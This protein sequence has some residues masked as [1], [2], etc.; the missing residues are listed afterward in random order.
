MHREAV[1]CLSAYICINQTLNRYW[2]MMQ[3]LSTVF[4]YGGHVN[5]ASSWSSLTAISS[6]DSPFLDCESSLLDLRGNGFQTSLQ[7]M[8][9]SAL[10][11]PSKLFVCLKFPTLTACLLPYHWGFMLWI[12]TISPASPGEWRKAFQ[13][14]EDGVVPLWC[15]DSPATEAASCKKLLQGDRDAKDWQDQLW[16]KPPIHYTLTMCHSS[17][18]RQAGSSGALWHNKDWP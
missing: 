10:A 6:I 12:F 3:L 15:S 16:Q 9:H 14:T 2:L 17:L 1:W 11:W 18:W 7:R 13:L 4:S 8:S 5:G